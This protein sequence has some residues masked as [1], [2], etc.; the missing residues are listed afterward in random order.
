MIT[1]L[2]GKKTVLTFDPTQGVEGGLKDK[3]IACVCHSH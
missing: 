1:L 3:I 2:P